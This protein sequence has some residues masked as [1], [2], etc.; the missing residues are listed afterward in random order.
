MLCYMVFYHLA[1]SRSLPLC[2]LVYDL[3]SN[4]KGVRFY[5]ISRFIP[6]MRDNIV[7]W[8]PIGCTTI[9]NTTLWS[10]MYRI[11]H[12]YKCFSNQ[13]IYITFKPAQ[14][15]TR[16]CRITELLLYTFYLFL[17]NCAHNWLYTDQSSILSS[18]NTATV[19]KSLMQSQSRYALAVLKY[20]HACNFF[21]HKLLQNEIKQER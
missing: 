19:S 8:A 11:M 1:N 21:R 3:L 17:D 9:I 4:S 7:C 5:K 14:L 2:R 12:F 18:W 10:A 6:R 20:F 13:H 16:I 15:W